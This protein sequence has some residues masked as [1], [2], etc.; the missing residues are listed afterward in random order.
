M[1]LNRT[2]R[3]A[4]LLA[5][6]TL[7]PW[8]GLA[9]ARGAQAPAPTDPAFPAPQRSFVVHSTEAHPLSLYDAIDGLREATGIRITMSAAVRSAL[10]I[11]PVGLIGE[12]ELEADDA[13][14][15]IE[16]LMVHQG[17]V[18]SE[19]RTEEPRILGIYSR[20]VEPGAVLKFRSATPAEVLD[21]EGHP[22][23]LVQVQLSC[24]DETSN[25][26]RRHTSGTVDE[27]LFCRS[28]YYGEDH[29]MVLRGPVMRVGAWIQSL[30]DANLIEVSQS[31]PSTP[32]KAPEA[33][34]APTSSLE[35][36]ANVFAILESMGSRT[37]S[38]FYVQ[39]LRA[40]VDN[41]RRS[42]SEGA[43]HVSVDFDLSVM[44]EDT[45]EATQ[46][47]VELLEFLERQEWCVEV[48]HR[49]TESRD[50]GQG[51]DASNVNVIVRQPHQ[52]WIADLPEPSVD[53]IVRE[54]AR[55][56][57]SGLQV[58]IHRSVRRVEK[59]FED[60]VHQVRFDGSPARTISAHLAFLAEVSR[61]LENGSISQISLG[62]MD[63]RGEQRGEYGMQFEVTSRRASKR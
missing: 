50:D 44:G 25:A 20:N 11:A 61:S 62:S 45:V 10:Q 54:V 46:A 28:Q 32:S 63:R 48:V 23:F 55:D 27:T 31:A 41:R 26:I 60:V 8:A 57:Q 6:L 37:D 29:G 40:N 35:A 51:I 47:Y 19:I 36:A 9:S 13:Y 5:A 22:A 1:R 49:G 53:V 33:V 15:F 3:A 39:D 4:C 52:P 2:H 12:V 17:F 59:N 43:G 14:G 56:T 38:Q 21:L 24:G 7:S 42:A 58:D 34:M 16:T 18:F 30:A